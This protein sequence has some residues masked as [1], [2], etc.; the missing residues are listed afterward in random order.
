MNLKLGAP[1]PPTLRGARVLV[2][3]ITGNLSI[4]QAGSIAV[5]D[6]IIW[7]ESCHRMHTTLSDNWDCAVILIEGDA[8][9]FHYAEHY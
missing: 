8:H 7:I 3:S 6:C 9:L 5:H 4:H 2:F 1:F